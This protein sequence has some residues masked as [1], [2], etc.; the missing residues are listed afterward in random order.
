[1]KKQTKKSTKTKQERGILAFRKQLQSKQLH[2]WQ[3]GMVLSVYNTVIVLAF[4]VLAVVTFTVIPVWWYVLVVSPIFFSVF[5]LWFSQQILH[6]YHRMLWDQAFIIA[7]AAML[8]FLVVF[9]GCLVMMAILLMDNGS[10]SATVSGILTYY[11]ML[12]SACSLF[13]GLS[14]LVFGLTHRIYIRSLLK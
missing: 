10:L 12:W 4:S 8:P 6:H 5:W 2:A 11:G 14:V 7:K 1:M 3:I 9:V 13:L